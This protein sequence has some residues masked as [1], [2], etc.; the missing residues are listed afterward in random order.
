M[1]AR[2][3]IIDFLKVYAFKPTHTAITVMLCFVGCICLEYLTMDHFRY[4]KFQHAS[5]VWRSQAKEIE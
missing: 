5:E 1:R 2:S 3:L 4:I